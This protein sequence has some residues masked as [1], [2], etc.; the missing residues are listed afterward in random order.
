MHTFEAFACHTSL[1]CEA[2][3]CRSCAENL[4]RPSSAA[5]LQLHLVNPW[6]AMLTMVPEVG[7]VKAAC[8]ALD[9]LVGKFSCACQRMNVVQPPVVVTVNCALRD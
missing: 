5:S 8:T 4:H 6:H 2:C 3:G 7:M 1:V 9:L